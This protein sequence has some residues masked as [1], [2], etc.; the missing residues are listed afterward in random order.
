M[1][2]QQCC[3]VSDS[4]VGVLFV[5]A[6]HIVLWIGSAVVFPVLFFC[7]GLIAAATA[8][9]FKPRRCFAVS[10][11]VPIAPLFFTRCV[12]VRALRSQLYHIVN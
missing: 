2:I 9:L 6:E 8:Y 4:T 5:F 11:S 3:G 10:E 12:C 1:K 7:N